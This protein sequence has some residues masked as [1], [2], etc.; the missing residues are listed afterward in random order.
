MNSIGKSTS[1]GPAMS[2]P[3]GI[4]AFCTVLFLAATSSGGEVVSLENDSTC[5]TI[6][7]AF[8]MLED[9]GGRLT[10]DEVSAPQM[11]D[12]F[13]PI[14]SSYQDYWGLDLGISSSTWWIRFDVRAEDLDAAQRNWILVLTNH[15]FIGKLAV[16]TLRRHHMDEPTEER[17]LVQQP[18]THLGSQHG[19]DV[20]LKLPTITTTPR[21]VY[22]KVQSDYYL[23]LPLSIQNASDYI[24]STGRTRL[25]TGM[26]YGVLA[27]IA[28]FNLLLVIFLRDKSSLWYVL[29]V[30]SIGLYFSG[31]QGEI[32]AVAKI[33]GPMYFAYMHVWGICGIVLFSL[34]FTRSFLRTR[35]F[36]PKLDKALLGY[37]T[38]AGVVLVI[39]PYM[40]ISPER[41]YVVLRWAT[42][43][44]GML[45]PFGIITPGIM[46]HL[47]DFKPARLYLAAWGVFALSAFFFAVPGIIDLEG[48]RVFQLG[49]SANVLLLTLA[50]VD[51]LRILRA[52]REALSVAKDTAEAALSESEEKFRSVADATTAHI[53]IVQDNHF[54]YANQT[55]LDHSG[56]T[57]AELKKIEITD[58]FTPEAIDVGLRA[59]AEAEDQGKTQ[60]RYESQDPNG[61][62]FEVNSSLV[63]LDGRDAF[64][65]TSFDITERKLAEQQMFRAEKMA[66]LGQIIAGVAHEINNP[67]NFIYFN[68]PILQK[69]IDS[70]KPF[71]DERATKDPGLRLLNMPYD[72]FI[73]DIYKLLE[74]MQH[75][76]SRITG[77]VSD[78]KNYV[79]SNDAEDKTPQAIGEV[80][81]QVM[82]V[83]GKQVRKLV[84]RLDVEVAEGLPLVNI[85]AGKIE[86]VLINL[87]INAGQAAT[88]ENSWVRL[89]A[90]QT[91]DDGNW[92][93][94][95]VEDNGSG[96]SKE[97]MDKVFEP[98]FT[99][100][101]DE[102]GTGLGLAISHQ[103]IE[104][105]GG[106][107]TV[108]SEAGKGT[109]FVIRL[110]V[111]P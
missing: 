77:I 91:T 7:D 3:H 49:C 27:L 19:K 65:N 45:A 28:I 48:W 47:Q 20:V 94:L 33:L 97:N 102:S 86:Q 81:E 59:W 30:A 42:I 73:E 67:N 88:N 34:M 84:K 111:N 51:R 37:M 11:S 52:E 66:S 72:M 56:T 41:G 29:F 103:I 95:R 25:L 79:R 104:D 71:L 108:K 16:Y 107:M 44:L 43:V 78:L 31:T 14:K 2:W 110:P 89:T 106:E 80:I 87:V 9:P 38:I 22:I 53:A 62:W 13:E 24:N 100:K 21:R 85:N 23:Y 5:T 15:R 35:K 4:G 61:T 40:S 46:R 18:N 6:I 60:F 75:G 82:T 58:F 92:V 90:A 76:S 54:V 63:E 64:I 99:T 12:T 57:W 50:I 39:S 32:S 96:I 105:H 74:N 36:T 26:F 55:F 70:I 69:Y 93:E 8:Q 83:V 101:A 98:F 17:W 1:A 68:L 109:T 10:I